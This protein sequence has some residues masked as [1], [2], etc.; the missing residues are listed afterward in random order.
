[1]LIQNCNFVFE[2]EA[3]CKK[4]RCKGINMKEMDIWTLN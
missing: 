4:H 3:Q 1:M 2:C